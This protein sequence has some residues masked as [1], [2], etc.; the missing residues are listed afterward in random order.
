M[1]DCGRMKKLLAE[2][3]EY[4][5]TYPKLAMDLAMEEKDEVIKI[6]TRSFCN[7]VLEICR[8]ETMWLDLKFRIQDADEGTKYFYKR[9]FEEVYEGKRLPVLYS[10]CSRYN[11][12]LKMLMGEKKTNSEWQ[13][14]YDFAIYDA[15]ITDIVSI[16]LNLDPRVLRFNIKCPFHDDKKPSLK[17]YVDSNRYHCHACG[18]SGK[19]VDFVMGFYNQSFKQ[20]VETIWTLR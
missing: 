5:R 20:A 15:R 8:I 13:E 18:A 16:A 10:R 1:G 14:K 17:V 2:R 9:V 12:Q 11:H 6:L 3:R 19:P 7:C 4:E